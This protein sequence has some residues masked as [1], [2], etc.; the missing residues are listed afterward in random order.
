[1]TVFISMLRA[2]NVGG[3]SR[4]RME[5]LRT[6][7]EAMGF[8]D[9][10]SLL[11]SGN[12]LFRSS[13]RDRAQLSRRIGQELERRFGLEIE[14]VIRTLAELESIFERSPVLSPQ[15]DP[16]KLLVMFLA[17]V[18]AA[19][20][21][22]RLAR[23]HKGPEMLEIRGPEVYLYYPDGVGRSRLTAAV[24]ESHLEVAGTA[25]NWNTL[26]KLLEAAREIERGAPAAR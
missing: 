20:A 17:G 18:P 2:V 23:S 1:M 9:V 5:P 12:V 3:T 16:A 8:R 11:Q 19:Q 22:A 4:I 26:T 7:Y 13:V 21:Q 24:I 6:A 25:R 15:A 10:R 14:V